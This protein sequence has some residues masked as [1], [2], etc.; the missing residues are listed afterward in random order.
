VWLSPAYS[1]TE[2]N[3]TERTVPKEQLWDIPPETFL[4]KH[5]EHGAEP[6]SK[7]TRREVVVE[8]AVGS[9]N[10]KPVNLSP[11]MWQLAF[12]AA[13]AEGFADRTVDD[14]GN[15]SLSPSAALAFGKAL[16]K[17]ATELNLLVALCRERRAL[18]V[19]TRRVM[20]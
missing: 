7:R 12:A 20:G 17:A 18:N 2:T 9:V 3:T 1:K 16:E 19:T 4:V 14:T 15:G 13:K 6:R 11:E 10:D 8:L 5:G